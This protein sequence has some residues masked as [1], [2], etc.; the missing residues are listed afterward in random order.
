MFQ[1]KL[2]S[3]KKIRHTRMLKFMIN[4]VHD[5]LLFLGL[6]FTFSTNLSMSDL[7]CA[8]RR[9]HLARIKESHPKRVGIPREIIPNTCSQS[10][11]NCRVYCVLF[12]YAISKR[13]WRA[14]ESFPALLSRVS[15]AMLFIK[16]HV[17]F[18]VTYA[19][20]ITTSGQHSTLFYSNVIHSQTC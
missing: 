11:N 18:D 5:Q 8:H 14:E 4:A 15:P 20:K 9:I 17:H 7:L 1:Y 19:L 16:S 12:I 13:Q 6:T 10:A 3:R 2:S